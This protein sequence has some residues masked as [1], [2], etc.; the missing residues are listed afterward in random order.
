MR[1]C[2]GGA[3]RKLGHVGLSVRVRIYL[4]CLFVSERGAGEAK[5]CGSSASQ[6]GDLGV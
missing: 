3:D 1:V 5:V 4:L 6:R 2:V